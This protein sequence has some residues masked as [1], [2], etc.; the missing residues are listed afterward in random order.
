MEEKD[1]NTMTKEELIEEIHEL[2]KEITRLVT[3]Y[4]IYESIVDNIKVIKD[5]LTL[6]EENENE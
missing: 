5:R 2:N 6:L 3:H 1:Y 4:S